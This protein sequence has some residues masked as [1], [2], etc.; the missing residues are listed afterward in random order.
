MPTTRLR[1]SLLP[2]SIT[3]QNFANAKKPRLLPP[4]NS[5]T[6][7]KFLI[8]MSVSQ[9]RMLL[10]LRILPPATTPLAAIRRVAAVIAARTAARTVAIG[11]VDVAGVGG[12]VAQ[13]AAA[14]DITMARADEIFLLQNMPRHKAIA[15]LAITRTV[16]PTIVSPAPP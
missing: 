3:P 8:S 2:T 16:A 12:A 11:V 14:V 10:P 1:K 15:I 6:I 7:R 13:E 9:N 5:L 4:W